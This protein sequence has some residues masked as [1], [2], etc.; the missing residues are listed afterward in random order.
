MTYQFVPVGLLRR[1]C[2]SEYVR[3]SYCLLLCL[4]RFHPYPTTASCY[5]VNATTSG[6]HRICFQLTSRDP[7]IRLAGKSGNVKSNVESCSAGQVGSEEAERKGY[8]PDKGGSSSLDSGQ[9]QRSH[10]RHDEDS[11]SQC[12][13]RRLMK[14][15]K[16]HGIIKARARWAFSVKGKEATCPCLSALRKGRYV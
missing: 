5:H 1:S 9:Q 6:S 7:G 2:T 14:C 8:L 10:C 12:A 11:L 13:T 4:Q 15:L 3:R 16:K